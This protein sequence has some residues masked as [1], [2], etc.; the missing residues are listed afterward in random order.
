M[1]KYARA[2]ADIEDDFSRQFN[3]ELFT[4]VVPI[5]LQNFISAAAISADV[6]M[7]GIVGQS[8][9]SAVSLAGQVTFVLTL[10]Y[11]GLAT[12][13]G[14]LT[15][16]YWGK[17]DFKAIQWVLNIAIAFSVSISFIF[18][19]ISLL[20]PQT[21]MGILTNDSELVRYGSDFLRA[22]SFSYLATGFSQ[23]YFSVVRS[24]E[25]ARLSAWISSTCLLLNIA[26]DALCIFVFFPG[27]PEMAVTAVAFSTV[28]ARFI[29]LGCCIIHSVKYG[30]IR[31]KIPWPGRKFIEPT[32]LKD[33][34]KYT[35]PVQ[36]NY[37]VWG[38]ALAA[39]ATIIGHVNADM[40]AANSVASV[41]KNLAIVLCG[42]IASGGAV[43]IGKYLGNNDL[44]RA[45]RAGNRINLYALLFG[46]LAGVTILVLKP[47]VFQVV[48][49]DTTAHD[50]LDGMLYICTYYCIGASL[51]STNIAGIFPAGGDPNFGFW[52]DCIVMWGIVLPLS[53]VSAFV[54]NV[55]PVLLFAI[56]SLD[57]IIKLPATAIRYR[58]YKWLKNI[59][60]EFT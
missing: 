58:Q 57:E 19:V 48:T 22:V 26:L 23:M 13:A 42:G 38:G 41:V 6:V 29:E 31:F 17:K 8:A 11:L 35:L 1:Q 36:G 10:F 60:R 46:V 50:Y 24:M 25:N 14:I 45:K 15:A 44:V 37:I 56:I 28:L 51:N 12:G 2:T 32:L 20:F 33:F 4:L 9:M 47:L 59:T 52:S 40:V 3:R 39:T 55:P 34:L 7:L 54:W 53:F 43:L 49:L 27:K 30:V 16:Q 21:L 5:A 18:F